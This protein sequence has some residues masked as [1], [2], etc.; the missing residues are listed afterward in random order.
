MASDE[1]HL[2]LIL[3]Q[4]LSSAPN[5]LLD[6]VRIMISQTRR[7]L[8][9]DSLTDAVPLV[10]AVMVGL[11]AVIGM[12]PSS[13]VDIGIRSYA[14]VAAVDTSN[15]LAILSIVGALRGRHWVSSRYLQ[16]AGV[17]GQVSAGTARFYICVPLTLGVHASWALPLTYFINLDSVD[18]WV[19]KQAILYKIWAGLLGGMYPTTRCSTECHYGWLLRVTCIY[20]CFG[21]PYSAKCVRT[22]T[23]KHWP[24]HT[25][26]SAPIIAYLHSQPFDLS[27]PSSMDYRHLK[28]CRSQTFSYKERPKEEE[29]RSVRVTVDTYVFRHPQR[30][31]CFLTALHLRLPICSLTLVNSLTH[32]RRRIL[33]LVV[34]LLLQASNQ[35]YHLVASRS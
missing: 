14:T 23:C 7:Y 25:A 9:A 27:S 28:Q 8:D 1:A 33:N 19:K 15:S 20:S 12:R 3:W 24:N 11:D 18:V 32:Y 10:L 26:M 5:H 34:H 31:P 17:I 6:T 16:S 30:Q 21:F 35:L 2:N 13:Q 4:T 22:V 29:E